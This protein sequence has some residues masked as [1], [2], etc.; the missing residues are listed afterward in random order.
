MWIQHSVRIEVDGKRFEF[1]HFEEQIAIRR[2]VPRHIFGLPILIGTTHCEGSN[3][4]AG[5]KWTARYCGLVFIANVNGTDFE[6]YIKQN[7]AKE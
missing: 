7:V 5:G 4:N 6:M 3:H 1:N 2:I